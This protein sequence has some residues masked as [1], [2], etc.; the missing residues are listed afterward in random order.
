MMT[1]AIVT[2]SSLIASARRDVPKITVMFTSG[3][4]SS[5]IRELEKA[6]R[7]LNDLRS[8]LFTIAIGNQPLFEQLQRLLPPTNDILHFKEFGDLTT[9]AVPTARRIRQST[10]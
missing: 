5:D 2:A 3:P 9:G 8:M 1:K 10:G 6:T 4:E 7:Q